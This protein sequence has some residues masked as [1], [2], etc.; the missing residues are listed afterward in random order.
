[1]RLSTFSFNI[2][3][4]SKNEKIEKTFLIKLKYGSLINSKFK[5]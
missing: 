3:I 2:D 1:M 5:L 4:N